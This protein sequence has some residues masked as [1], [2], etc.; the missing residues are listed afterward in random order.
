MKTTFLLVSILCMTVAG[1][2]GDPTIDIDEAEALV[3]ETD[4][5]GEANI[6]TPCD[7][8]ANEHCED[9]NPGGSGPGGGGVGGGT[10]G[11]S[12]GGSS[13]GNPLPCLGSNNNWCY[14]HQRCERYTSCT[15][16]SGNP[17]YICH[18]SHGDGE[19]LCIY[20]PPYN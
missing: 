15:H 8:V 12:G 20:Y 9:G 13:G 14:T 17:D 7:P 1:C 10:G 11:G 5:G 3:S 19:C 6:I 16:P 18:R 4:A 2:I